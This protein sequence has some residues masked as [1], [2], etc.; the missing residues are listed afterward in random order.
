MNLCFLFVI[1]KEY[2]AGN[3]ERKGEKREGEKEKD[4]TK[5]DC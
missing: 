3:L 2:K 4:R 1:R 5:K